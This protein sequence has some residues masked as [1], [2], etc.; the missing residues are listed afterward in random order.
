MQSYIVNAGMVV[1][2]NGDVNAKPADGV[3]PRPRWV[4]YDC[5]AGVEHIRFNRV[6]DASSN[7]G[8]TVGWFASRP[9][10]E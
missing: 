1:C 10:A 4:D 2:H 8:E 7:K 6:A 3:E 5:R 9:I